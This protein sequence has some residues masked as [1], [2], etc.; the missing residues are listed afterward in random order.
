[1]NNCLRRKIKNHKGFTLLELMIVIA[2]TILLA[3]T[4][5]V[6]FNPGEKQKEQRDA[7]RISSLSQIASAMELYYAEYKRYP[8]S[9]T[10]LLNFNL[11]VNINDPV[12]S[13]NC[14][15]KYYTN[16]NKSYYEIYSVKESLNFTIPKGQNF[17]SEIA[18]NQM[19]GNLN[20][21]GC[22]IVSNSSKIFKITGGVGP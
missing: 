5:I 4:T 10:D 11:K 2:I 12:E 16:I 19:L 21:S 20:F 8:T 9:L 22:S 13:L 3:A 7:L 15:F 17:I 6:V 18:P 1:M 14:N